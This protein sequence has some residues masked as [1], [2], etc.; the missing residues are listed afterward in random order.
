MSTLSSEQR[1]ELLGPLTAIKG[2]AEL[3][4]QDSADFTEQQKHM[5]DQITIA[6]QKLHGIIE[7]T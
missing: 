6:V 2:Y 3:L 1:H 7:S 4:E 5:L